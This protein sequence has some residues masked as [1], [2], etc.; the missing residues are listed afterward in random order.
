[1]RQA[2]GDHFDYNALLGRLSSFAD[3]AEWMLGRRAGRQPGAA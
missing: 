2:G 1:M 3:A